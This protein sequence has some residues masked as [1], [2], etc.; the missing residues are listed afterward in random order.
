VLLQAAQVNST[1][2]D[3]TAAAAAAA[4]AVKVQAARLAAALAPDCAAAAAV[5]QYRVWRALQLLPA[6]L[7]LVLLLV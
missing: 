6:V 2:L 7:V 5:Q 1:H 4:A 3:L